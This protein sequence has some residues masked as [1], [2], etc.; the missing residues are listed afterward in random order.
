MA[1]SRNFGVSMWYREV[2][3]GPA[4]P[5]VL[6]HA[7]PLNGKMFEPQLEAL[8]A[9]RRVVVPDFPGFGYS[10]RTP[11]QPDVGYYAGCVLGL[12]DRLEIPRVVLGGV[13]MGGYVAFECVRSFPERI[14]GLILANTRPDPDSEEIRKTRKE[15]A[16][17]VAR[18]G[19]GILPDLQMERLLSPHTRENDGGL[20][21]KVRAIILENTPDGAVAALGAMRERP[22]SE[23]TLGEISV[24]TL[25][26]GGEDDAISSPGVM[27]EMAG[28][29][30]GSRHVTLT[31]VGH[32]S[33]L[34]DPEGFNGA[35]KEFL[36]GL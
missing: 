22:D 10:P 7:F 35:V 15:M 13:S 28:K 17:R 2:G 6:L 21:E 32:L 18:E 3:E 24:P 20:A 33:N 30:R 34:E 11:A 12:L 9:D 16:L 19:I 31:N 14:S 29:I 27:G 1:D 8:S 36:G 26:I 4:D 23:T 25:V 5:L